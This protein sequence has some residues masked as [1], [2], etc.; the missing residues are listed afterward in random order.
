MVRLLSQNCDQ[1]DAMYIKALNSKG[2]PTYAT[3][4]SLAWRYTVILL[5]MVYDNYST[6][7]QW[8]LP[9]KCTITSLVVSG[10]L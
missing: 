5:L 1:L 7:R 10:C 8:E 6:G 3:I 2:G 9:Y 4:A